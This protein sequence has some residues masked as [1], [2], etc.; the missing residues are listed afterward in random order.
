MSIQPR[1]L[2]HK[3]TST[4]KLASAASTT[5]HTIELYLDY[6]CPFSLK[7]FTEVYHRLLPAISERFPA[8]AFTFVFRQQIQPWHPSST[9]VHEAALAVER[10]DPSKFWAFS[11]ALFKASHEFYDTATYNETRAQTYDRLAT[12]AAESVGV[13]KQQVLELLAIPPSQDTPHNWGSKVTDDLKLF[14]KQ[15]RQT[16]IHVSPTVLV[17]GVVDNGI[18]SGWT[19]EQWLEKLDAVYKAN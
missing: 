5:P 10:I 12:L 1:F 8:G 16:S 19:T 3:L 6:V 4:S 17:D 11:D 13:E 14:I 15:G 2:A 18:S 9:L 7:L